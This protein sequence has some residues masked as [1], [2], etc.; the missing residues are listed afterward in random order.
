MSIPVDLRYLDMNAFL[1]AQACLVDFRPAAAAVAAS[2]L[3][4]CQLLCSEA[5]VFRHLLRRQHQPLA[6]PAATANIGTG[7]S[8]HCERTDGGTLLRR[9]RPV[10]QGSLK[11]LHANTY[12]GPMQMPIRP[13]PR[14]CVQVEGK[15]CARCEN[16]ALREWIA[17]SQKECVHTGDGNGLQPYK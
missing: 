14:S 15:L 10:E 13:P 6:P 11:R 16:V 9:D 5:S 8:D 1:L 4:Q 2:G 12:R 17:A 3:G 7:R